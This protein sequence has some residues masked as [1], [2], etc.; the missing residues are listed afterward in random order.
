[1]TEEVEKSVNILLEKCGCKYSLKK[2]LGMTEATSAA[3]ASFENVNEF[4]SVGIPFPKMIIKTID[5]ETLKE[6]KYGVDGEI[7]ISGPTIMQGY[8]GKETET[9]EIIK[10]HTD[11]KKW[12][13]TGDLGHITEDGII[14]VTGRIKRIIMTKG[15]DGNITKMFPDRIEKAIHSHYSVGICCVI[16]I[17]DNERINYPKAYVVL[18]EN[19]VDKT[20]IKSEIL[21]ICEQ[22]LPNY[23]V[24]D[25]IELI[26][27]L[28]RTSRGKIDYR[29]LEERWE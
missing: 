4:E 11:G 9:A 22:S 8:Y 23:M 29:A 24:P 7:C 19:N 5:T 15:S 26:E 13:H 2:G 3:S 6:T 27:D 16:G 21:D 20:H 25:E 18:K 12:L 28:P 1:M 10:E 14:F 17:K